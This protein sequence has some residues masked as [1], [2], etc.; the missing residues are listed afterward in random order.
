[1]VDGLVTLGQAV[2][3][4]KI[5]KREVVG[6]SRKKIRVETKT[7]QNWKFVLS[8]LA[9]SFSVIIFNQPLVTQYFF[10]WWLQMASFFN[11]KSPSENQ[12][13]V[14]FQIRS[15]ASTGHLKT[16][17]FDDRTKMSGFRMAS[18]DRFIKKRVIII[19]YSCQN[20]QG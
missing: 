2:L 17:P 3:I 8:L 20:G 15:Y 5:E 13:V 19:L 6:C 14:V 9:T 12:T 4:L 1:V 7:R 16:G 10:I 11:V 18:L